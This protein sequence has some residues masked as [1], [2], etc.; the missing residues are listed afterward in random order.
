MTAGGK[1]ISPAKV[2]EVLRRSPNIELAMVVGEGERFLGALLVPSEALLK[3][4][5][6]PA[7]IQGTLQ[8]DVD[9]ANRGLEPHERVRKFCFVQ[10]PFSVATGE[11]SGTLKLRRAV[12]AEKHRAL[13]AELFVAT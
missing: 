4:G 10:A 12:V 11:L 7:E 13:L 1:K 9:L 5:S 2:E 6:D 8:L 3:R